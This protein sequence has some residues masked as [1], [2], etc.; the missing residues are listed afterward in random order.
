MKNKKTYY[1]VVPKI[2]R[3]DENSRGEFLYEVD[4]EDHVVCICVGAGKK[5]A[6]LKKHCVG[7]KSLKD[8]L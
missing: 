7:F 3:I 5:I 1:V 8:A 2:Y 4:Q 6:E